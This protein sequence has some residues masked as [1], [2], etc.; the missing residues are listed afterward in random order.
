MALLTNQKV[1][2]NVTEGRFGFV[3]TE[4]FYS[5]HS[6]YRVQV[7]KDGEPSHGLYFYDL[8]RARHYGH[9]AIENLAWVQEY[10]N[11]EHPDK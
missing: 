11:T 9:S 8:N 5:N 3:I 4:S 7:L 6:E 10:A 1:L 2:E